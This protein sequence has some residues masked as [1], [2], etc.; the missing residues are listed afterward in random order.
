MSTPS[1]YRPPI[2]PT[3]AAA[4]RPRQLRAW[5]Q[6]CYDHTTRTARRAAK[7]QPPQTDDLFGGAA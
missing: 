2:A 1:T 6:A 4:L 5:C 3:Q 7:A